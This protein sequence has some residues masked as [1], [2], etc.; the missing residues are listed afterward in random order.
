MFLHFVSL[1]MQG[2][3]TVDISVYP[4]GMKDILG[5]IL[6]LKQEAARIEAEF[7]MVG[8]SI[9]PE[10]QEV[11]NSIKV[12]EYKLENI[13]NFFARTCSFVE[14]AIADY[15]NAEEAIKSI[16][17]EIED[18]NFGHNLESGL[19]K[20]RKE[21]KVY[22]STFSKVLNMD[23]KIEPCK[24]FKKEVLMKYTVKPGKIGDGRNILVRA[25]KSPIS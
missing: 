19:N 5:Q 10:F 9:E 25:W 13:C 20:T 7:K 4:D 8:R 1:V 11:L 2:V 12:V 14:R 3:D 21:E 6:I 17:G 22:K 24:I 18:L 15:I 23:L 16:I